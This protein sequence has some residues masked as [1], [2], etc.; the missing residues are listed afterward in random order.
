MMNEVD[1]YEDLTQDD[2]EGLAEEARLQ[3]W[4]EESRSAYAGSTDYLESSLRRQWEINLHNFQGRH[5]D[6]SERK[7]KIFRPK[8]RTSLRSHEASL[9]AALFTNNDVL[10]VKGANPNDKVQDISAKLN[11][12]LV[13]HRL[14]VTIPWFQLI[15]S[16]K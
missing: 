6:E 10:D 15:G 9:A 3:A 11:K 2:I 1:Q 4:L 7:K 8:I 14:D 5:R 12:E 16:M 13:Q